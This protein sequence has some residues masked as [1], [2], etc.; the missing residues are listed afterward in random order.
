[1]SDE[2]PDELLGRIRML[3]TDGGGG[4]IR[5][6]LGSLR[7]FDAVVIRDAQGRVLLHGTLT[8]YEPAP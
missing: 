8:V 5:Y 7:P 1:E 3:D 4:V 6:F 2:V